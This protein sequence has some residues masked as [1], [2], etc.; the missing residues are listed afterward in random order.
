[1]HAVSGIFFLFSDTEGF[2]VV[3]DLLRDNFYQL[4]K[5]YNSTIVRWVLQALVFALD[6]ALNR[7]TL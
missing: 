6:C 5:L 4:Y 2:S 1:M 3:V 7:M